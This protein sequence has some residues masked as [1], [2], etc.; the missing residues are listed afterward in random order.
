VST[1]FLPNREGF[2]LLEVLIA[3][4]L[5][6]VV[7]SGLTQVYV[8]GRSQVDYEEDRRKATAVLQ[9]QLDAIRQDHAY[10]EL[11]ALTDVAYQVDGRRFV[12][13]H[14]VQLDTPE[15]QAATIEMTVTWQARKA[16]GV[17][18]RQ[19]TMTSILGRSLPL[20]VAP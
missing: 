2:T 10:D 12:V 1:R 9:S 8:R 13:R 18:P 19:M 5:L 15:P 7:F 20:A 14:A 3:A 11:P 6:L 17:V 16:S 4:F